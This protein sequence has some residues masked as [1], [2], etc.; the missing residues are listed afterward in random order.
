MKQSELVIGVKYKHKW[1]KDPLIL[2]RKG[3]AS[4]QG[5]RNNQVEVEY[6][7]G[8]LA[9]IPSRQ[10]EMEWS[11]WEPTYLAQ[12]AAA[13]QAQRD[14]QKAIEDAER[15]WLAEHADLIEFLRKRKVGL[16]NTPHMPAAAEDG[17]TRY[18]R[19]LS[20]KTA[21]TIDLELLEDL[22]DIKKTAIEDIK[23]Q[24]LNR[25]R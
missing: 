6:P 11:K 21:V 3:L 19:L 20:N 5:Q 12:Q 15:E 23:E 22:L 18:L 13:Q 1:H 8:R 4:W 16:L 10:L 17:M 2:K 24:L 14:R 9:T 7:D 25:L